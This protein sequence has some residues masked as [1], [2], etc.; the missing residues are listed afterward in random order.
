MI[1]KGVFCSFRVFVVVGRGENGEVKRRCEARKDTRCYI[2]SLY[3]ECITVGCKAAKLKGLSL[4]LSLS[5]SLYS[6]ITFVP[7]P[8]KVPFLDVFAHRHVRVHLLVGVFVVVSS[9]RDLDANALRD[10]ANAFGPNGFV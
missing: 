9:S 2:Y 7:N 1:S 4:S 10:V 3:D 5:L 6:V 8:L